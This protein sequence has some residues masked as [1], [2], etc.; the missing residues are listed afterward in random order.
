MKRHSDGL[1]LPTVSIFAALLGVPQLAGAACAGQWAL[2]D[3]PE[4]GDPDRR[5]ILDSALRLCATCPALADCADWYDRL[6]FDERPTGV[7][8]GQFRAF[9][10]RPA[11]EAA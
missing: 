7:V 4:R 3:E 9:V 5:E 1:G 11:R 2:M 8:A 10:R 6:P